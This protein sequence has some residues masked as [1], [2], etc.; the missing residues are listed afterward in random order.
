MKSAED[1]TVRY[2]SE[3][4]MHGSTRTIFS[5]SHCQ[6]MIPIWLTIFSFYDVWWK[7]AGTAREATGVVAYASCLR[8]Y[9]GYVGGWSS[10][11]KQENSFS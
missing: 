8:V 11:Q 5:S 2:Y 7:Y 4:V 10:L 6:P 3:Q 9:A 1:M